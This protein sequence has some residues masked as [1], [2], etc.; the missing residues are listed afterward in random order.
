MTVLGTPAEE[1]GGGKL[2]MIEANVFDDIDVVLMAHPCT[3]NTARPQL[4]ANKK[5][6][7]FKQTANW[8]FVFLLCII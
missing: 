5:Y 1:G 2:A 6:V 8:C 4:L 7:L 3:H